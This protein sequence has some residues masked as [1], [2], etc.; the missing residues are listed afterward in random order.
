MT[1]RFNNVMSFAQ[2]LIENSGEYKNKAAFEL[3]KAYSDKI[4]NDNALE[5]VSRE[6]KM[7]EDFGFL[8]LMFGSNKTN[9]K[10]YAEISRRLQC[11]A[12]ITGSINISLSKSPVITEVWSS[13]RLSD[14]LCRIKGDWHQTPWHHFTLYL[15]VGILF[16]HTNGNHS[17][18]AGC[19]RRL[20]CIT[21][22]ED[23][24]CDMGS[25]YE[26]LMFDGVHYRKVCDNSV[27][28]RA[29]SF[30]FGCMFEIGRL[31]YEN[32]LSYTA[33]ME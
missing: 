30:E 11:K 26:Y 17:V 5:V 21:V 12:G 9:D 18:Y 6:Y 22:T 32:N 4:I 1:K 7:K 25:L 3:M 24:I 19:L 14:S 15:P 29:Y 2:C 23:D 16:V 13:H 27:V 20:G 28:G 33:Y 31:I 8:C 10:D